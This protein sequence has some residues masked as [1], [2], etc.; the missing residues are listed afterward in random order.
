MKKEVSLETVARHAGVAKSTV[1]FVL[2]NKGNVAPETK[3]KV[4]ASL[5]ALGYGKTNPTPAPPPFVRPSIPA[6]QD[7]KNILIYVNPAVREFE[8]VSIYMAGLR[9]Y[10]VKEGAVVYSFAM[11]TSELEG[12][13]QLQFL[14]QATQPQAILLIGIDSQNAFLKHALKSGKPCLVINRLSD[15][16]D[17]SYISI[18][19]GEA[20]RDA[21]RYLLEL[22]H[23]HFAL[24]VESSYNETEILRLEAFLDELSQHGP[25]VRAA[26]VRSYKA[27][28]RPEN[29]RASQLADLVRDGRLPLNQTTPLKIP[30]SLPVIREAAQL[31]PAF[32]PTCLVA[33]TD[34]VTG[35][36]QEGLQTAGLNVPR[37]VSVMSLN[38][39]S[40]SLKAT[41]QTTAIDGL[42]HEIGYMAGRVLENLI[43]NK[44]IRCQ[45][46]QIG[47]RLVERG[48]TARPKSLA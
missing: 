34:L 35:P 23:R 48:S 1:S 33:S 19:H 18:N 10:A 21:A 42:W 6:N 27:P 26:L 15:D 25:G 20:G 39:S 46:I 40:I 2:N 30:A 31:D 13:V 32:K 22:G 24:A 36:A 5:K 3:E 16:P 44:L 14:E 9:E 28:D 4:E 8:V 47:H 7:K 12:S 43:D 41:P 37:D 29:H 17:L 38:S 45:K 11:S